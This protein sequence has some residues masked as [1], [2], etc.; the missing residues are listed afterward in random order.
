L[1][2]I[3]SLQLFGN[4]VDKSVYGCSFVL[5][6]HLIILYMKFTLQKRVLRLFL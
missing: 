6:S 1:I 3:K 4:G 5:V 2:L